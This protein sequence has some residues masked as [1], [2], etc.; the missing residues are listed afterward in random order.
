MLGIVSVALSARPAGA[1]P[2][3][4]ILGL[5]YE[6]DLGG[7][8]E[9]FLLPDPL[10]D[11]SIAAD[12]PLYV[13]IRVPWVLVEQARG[14][15][16]WN[17]V[18]R[19]VE[20]YRAAN[21]VVILCLYGANPALEAVAPAPPSRNDGG[22]KDWLDFTRETALHFKG[23]VRYYE[24]WDEPN[25]EPAWAGGKVTEYA[26]L[27]K[28]SSVTIR[29]A[30]PEA[31][32]VQGGIAIASEGREADLAW[33]A[34]LYAQDVATYVD[35]LPIHPSPEA[36]LGP[37][38]ARAYD[39]LLA[40]DPSA[41]LWANQ[42]RL[43][44]RTDREK[45][46]EILSGFITA[47][48]EGA[49]VVT[50]DL[51]ADVEGRPELPGVL[52]D[53]HKLF[54]PTYSRVPGA[55]VPFG[56]AGEK[57]A[58]PP[59][60]VVAYKF[61]DA[62][63]FQ[64][65][66]GFWTPTPPENG[67][68]TLQIDTAAVRGVV[69]YDIVGGAAGPVSE[70]RPDFKSNTT[71]VPVPLLARPLVMQYARVAIKGFEAEK[72]Q[73]RI[74]ETGLVTAE[75]VIAGHQSF[76]AD[77]NYRMR[78]Y[79]AQA[80]LTYHA[81][82]AGSD[83][84][85]VSYD[86][87]FFKKQ[88]AGAEWVQNALYFN[89]VRWK[90]KE[91][92]E[93]PIPQ[94][95]KVFTLPLD[96]NLDKGYTYEYVGREKV[97]EYD[98][99]VVDFTPIERARSLYRGRAWIET[100]TFAPVRVRT[101]QTNLLPPVVSNEET[102]LFAPEQ[103]VDGTTYWLVNRVEGQ[104]ILTV[105]G[106]D[107]VLLREIDFKD[108]LINDTGFE[109]AREAAYRSSSQMLRDTDAGLRYLEATETGERVV[110]ETNTRSALLGVAGVFHQPNLGIPVIPLA[111]VNYFN[112]NFR[113]RDIQV[114]AFLAGAV[115]TFT[116]TNPSL[117]GKRL[118]ATFEVLG[119]VPSFTDALFIEGREREESGVKSRTQSLSGGL[120]RPLGNFFR[121]K[122][123]FDLEY[124]NHHRAEDTDT[125][126]VPSDT[127]VATPGIEWEFN[128]RA[129]A[130]TAAGRRSFRQRWDGWGDSSPPS[131]EIM[132]AFPSSTCDSPGSCL[133]EFDPAQK[134]YD[135]YEFSV[136]KQ[137][138]LPKFQKVR[139]EAEWFTGSRLDRFSEFQ[140][141]FFGTRL[142]G[143]SGSGVRFDR[144]GIARAEYSFNI[145]DVIRFDAGVDYGYVKDGLT[146]VEYNRFTGF[147]FSGNLMGP[148]QT[149]V[150]FD[151]GVAVLSDFPDLKGNTEFLIGLLKYFPDSRLKSRRA[152]GS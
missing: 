151:I 78:H 149:I 121:V 75:E 17:E 56:P 6:Y 47:Q 99:H 127:F 81:R 55:E 116:L 67:R 140:F 150:Q 107:V 146:S 27:L 32:I 2:R 9:E 88:A 98:C 134:N 15:Y 142:R 113:G 110:K 93:L 62:G 129:W 120:G 147:G 41:Q 50:F 102:D 105:V 36:A 61:F 33:Q 85:D 130:V 21:F 37:V 114:N 117:L 12:H 20:P 108:F 84:I 16:D 144:G 139:F 135:R 152:S 118:D 30:D 34:A 66:I 95:E 92:P 132:A 90:G 109:E 77:Q 83:T 68:A 57:A 87:T 122:G 48:G 128:R 94:P 69:N 133:A 7:S 119:I 106:R 136:A 14:I 86:N 39:L 82:L 97:G 71:R 70:A 65:L 100:R 111:G 131:A 46:V 22:L 124:T 35:V 64:G 26:F 45:A 38:V 23:R 79:R 59:E 145:A 18:E 73:I 91:L 72:E 104:Q 63:L 74:R 44:G 28:N 137:Y 60:G 10:N 96:I 125:F 76:M 53:I 138:F 19:I 5:G 42:V 143:F 123:T 141:S 148:W 13:R 8:R 24:I 51:E 54:L 1:A 25:R 101:V 80:L 52:L 115:N 89:G 29:S 4:P 40:Q 103:G 11:T 58:R 3:V 126:V 49:A 31:L 112:Y 43:H